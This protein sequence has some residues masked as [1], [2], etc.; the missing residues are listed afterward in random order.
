MELPFRKENLQNA[1]NRISFASSCHLG[2][3]FTKAP[4][5]FSHNA[6]LEILGGAARLEVL[7]PD[8]VLEPPFI[9]ILAIWKQI[10]QIVCVMN[11]HST[12]IHGYLFIAISM[13]LWTLQMYI[14]W[15]TM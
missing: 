15:L 11:T 13:N 10:Q 4:C 5:P 9:G 1:G 8:Q 2:E 7:G 14:H 12:Y 3:F 6:G